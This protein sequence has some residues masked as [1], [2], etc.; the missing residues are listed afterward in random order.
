VLA[1]EGFTP[2]GLNPDGVTK[3]HVKRG[4]KA[5]KSL[6]LLAFLFLGLSKKGQD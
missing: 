1:G 2:D 3:T 6:I 5:S 4:S